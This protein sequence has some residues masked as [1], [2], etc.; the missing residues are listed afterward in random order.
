[1]TIQAIAQK[2]GDNNLTIHFGRKGTSDCF[3]FDRLGIARAYSD[4][5][6][7]GRRVSFDREELAAT[8]WRA[9]TNDPEI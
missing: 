8:D 6:K 2:Q 1:M 3:W 4:S 9:V 5:D 7:G